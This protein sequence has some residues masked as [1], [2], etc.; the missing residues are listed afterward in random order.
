[1]EVNLQ[2][3]YTGVGLFLET[4]PLRG[5]SPA[6]SFCEQLQK[7]LAV[8][9]HSSTHHINTAGKKWVREISRSGTDDL[10]KCIR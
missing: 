2:L 9:Y 1:M 7:L 8:P 6:F 10:D 4:G 3:N 5:V